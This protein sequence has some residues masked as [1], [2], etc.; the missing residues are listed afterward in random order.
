MRPPTAS[1]VPVLLHVILSAHLRLHTAACSLLK[2][3]T[4]VL[5]SHPPDLLQSS[6]ANVVL[7][8]GLYFSTSTLPSPNVATY[9]IAVVLYDAQRIATHV[10]EPY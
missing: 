7:H 4:P 1:C 6:H 3:L 8:P 9:N 2:L 5:C 10:G